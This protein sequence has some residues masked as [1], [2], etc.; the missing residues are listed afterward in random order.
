VTD[1]LRVAVVV[2][3]RISNF[4]DIDALCL[5]PGLDVVLVDS[6]RGLAGADV[7][8]LAGT[9]AT[10]ADLAW[11]RARGLADAVVSHAG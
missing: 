2:L 7:V 8:V 5:E 6:P 9:R 11:L 3:P 4:T 1:R 10:I